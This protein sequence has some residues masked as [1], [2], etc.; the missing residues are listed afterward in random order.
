MS[1]ISRPLNDIHLGMV[2]FYYKM[3]I[4]SHDEH[5]KPWDSEVPMGTLFANRRNLRA[6]TEEQPK[7]TPF[8]RPD[9]K[10]NMKILA[11]THHTRICFGWWMRLSSQINSRSKQ[12]VELFI[13]Y[14]DATL[15]QTYRIKIVSHHFKCHI[16]LLLILGQHC[17]PFS[18]IILSNKKLPLPYAKPWF[19]S[20]TIQFKFAKKGC[21]WPSRQGMV[22]ICHHLRTTLAGHLQMLLFITSGFCKRFPQWLRQFVGWMQAIHWRFLK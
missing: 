9:A 8:A 18:D 21:L 13:V 2:I 14:W 4:I 12:N 19:L 3:L 15:L 20:G 22:V 5:D 10:I 11:I 6:A 16:L 1:S 17:N 7:R